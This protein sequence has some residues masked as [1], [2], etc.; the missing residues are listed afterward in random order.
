MEEPVRVLIKA[1]IDW[2]RSICRSRFC[3]N[4]SKPEGRIAVGCSKAQL[5]IR[6]VAA[7]S[8]FFFGFIVFAFV[9]FLFGAVART[10]WSGAVPA[11]L[12]DSH[13]RVGDGKIPVGGDGHGSLR[14]PTA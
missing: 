8:L 7:P 1:M 11:W 3:S 14:F 4:S 2:E 6:I 13:P 10:A 12:P 9:L 5:Q